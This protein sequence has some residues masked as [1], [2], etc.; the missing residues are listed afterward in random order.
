MH[1]R[2]IEIDGD[3][4][5]LTFGHEGV[6]YR[7]A[8]VMYDKQTNSK[9]VHANG[10]AMKGPLAGKRLNILRSRLMRWENWRELHPNTKVL[11]RKGRD[12]FMGT[13]RSKSHEQLGISVGQ[14]PRATLYP[15]ETVMSE[16]IINDSVN[17]RPI[18]V[19]VDPASKN[20]AVFSRRINGRTLTFQPV[21]SESDEPLMVDNQTGTTW[22]QISGEAVS[23]PL[24][25]TTLNS[26]IAVS[27]RIDRWNAIYEEGTVYQ[28]NRR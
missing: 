12:G 15:F 18:V 17:N 6:L 27:W 3:T 14:G 23:G 20:H 21:S 22:H 10:L 11:A 13:F 2:V 25:G 16:G 19:T 24:E 4:K 26:M 5:T 1:S 7:S 9:W 8:F 28:S